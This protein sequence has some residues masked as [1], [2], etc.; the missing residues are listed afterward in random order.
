MADDLEGLRKTALKN[1]EMFNENIKNVYGNIQFACDQAARNITDTRLKAIESEL[2]IISN[3][4]HKSQSFSMFLLDV[5]LSLIPVVGGYLAEMGMK[6]MFQTIVRNERNW[7]CFQAEF[8]I[9][10]LKKTRKNIANIPIELSE[11]ASKEMY[12]KLKERFANFEKTFNQLRNNKESFFDSLKKIEST[13]LSDHR[14][15]WSTPIANDY[16]QQVGSK[17]FSLTNNDEFSNFDNNHKSE[18]SFTSLSIGVLQRYKDSPS[19]LISE[20]VKTI[21]DMQ[22]ETTNINHSICKFAI[23]INTNKDYLKLRNELILKSNSNL[24][25]GTKAQKFRLVLSEYFEAFMWVILLGDPEKWFKVKS[26]PS[27]GGYLQ[28]VPA[29]FT[30]ER[31]IPEIIEEHLLK[32]FH[33]DPNDNNPRDF[34]NYYKDLKLE[35][36]DPNHQ[37]NFNDTPGLGV[38]MGYRYA[39]PNTPIRPPEDIASRDFGFAD[40]A[41]AKLQIFFKEINSM[42]LK[43]IPIINSL[44]YTGILDTD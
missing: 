32:T 20:I 38:P 29:Y 36:L 42:Q 13:P 8:I 18:E 44:T 21:C 30:V 26:I 43:S 39:T 35:R 7:E 25:T 37:L 3:E 14:W 33:P 10:E 40:T 34:L 12:D 5:A 9:N 31:N 41:K 16:L 4:L 1:L 27:K 2:T 19:A 17:L 23:E 24:P 6:N 22:I 11:K 15:A 28:S